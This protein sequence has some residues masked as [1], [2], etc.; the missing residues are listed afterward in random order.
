M[1]SKLILVTVLIRLGVAAAISSVLVRARRFRVLL[2]REER[3]LGEKIEIVL[4]I[5]IPIPSACWCAAG[6]ATSTPLTSRLKA[7]S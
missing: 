1:D 3:N 4:I 6:S 5:G 2:F 7:P